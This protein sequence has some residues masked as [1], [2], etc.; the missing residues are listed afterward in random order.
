MS[1][2][3]PLNKCYSE[4]I[5]KTGDSAKYNELNELIYL[6]I[7]DEHMGYRI[8]FGEIE[9]AANGIRWNYNM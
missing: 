7:R 8:E 4:I 2:Q 6:S 1:V 9:N 3:N 5:Y